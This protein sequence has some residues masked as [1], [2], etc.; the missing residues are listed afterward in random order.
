MIFDDQPEH[1]S[2][3]DI[4][5]LLA[6]MAPPDTVLAAMS[7]NSQIPL[8]LAQF[9]REK[10]VE[11]YAG[12]MTDPRFQAHTTRFDW[13]IRCILGYARGQ[14]RPKQADVS[15]FLN[16]ELVAARIARLEDPIEDFFTESLPTRRGD[17]LLIS[18]YWE[19]AALHTETV[20]SAFADLPDAP[21]KEASLRRAFALLKL[22]TA[23]VER[24]GLPR[25]AVDKILKSATARSST[26][27]P[28]GGQE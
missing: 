19:K 3:E 6:R 20:L 10:S 13:A 5:K 12:L 21:I 27:G 4:E 8:A 7:I 17:Y 28:D 26:S 16:R 1:P 23:I 9:S 2:I 25:W 24:A 15:H 18:G 14:R 22:S 11:I